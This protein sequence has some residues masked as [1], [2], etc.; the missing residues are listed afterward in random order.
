ML[1]WEDG[2][3]VRDQEKEI[4]EDERKLTDENK[5]QR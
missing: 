5:R 2:E 1:Q 4:R 3:V